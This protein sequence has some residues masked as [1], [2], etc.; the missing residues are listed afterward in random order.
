MALDGH[1]KQ[2]EDLIDIYGLKD[3]L[4]TVAHICDAKAEHLST[5]WQDEMKANVWARNANRIRNMALTLE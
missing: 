5:D 2:L 4:D 3:T 1:D